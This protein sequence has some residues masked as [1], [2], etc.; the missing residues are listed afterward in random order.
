MLT[1]ILQIILVLV[2]ALGG[3]I[4]SVDK[5]LDRFGGFGE[6]QVGAWQAFPDAGTANADPYARARAARKAVLALGTA[7]GLAFYASKDEQGRDLQRGCTYRLEGTTSPT[8]FWTLYAATPD[9]TT[10]APRSGLQAALHSRDV[11]YKA[12]GSILITISPDAASGNWLPLNGRGPFVL[13]MT[14]YDTPIA[15][16]AG[17]TDQSMPKLTLS[18]RACHG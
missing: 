3:G 2:I 13:V 8:R 7:E 5:V 9:L 1:R 4:W 15:T 16:S 12:D 14:L 6:L 18:S 10:I 17:L 11:L